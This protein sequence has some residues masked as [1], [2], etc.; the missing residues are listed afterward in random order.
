MSLFTTENEEVACKVCPNKIQVNTSDEKLHYICY[1]IFFLSSRIVKMQAA[2]KKIYKLTC[3][4]QRYKTI[5]G[6]LQFPQI[7]TV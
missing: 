4:M 1:K 2:G 3:S 7:I 5:A 6:I